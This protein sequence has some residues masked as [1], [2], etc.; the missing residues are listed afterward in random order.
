MM[1]SFSRSAS[2]PKGALTTVPSTLPDLIAAMR[3]GS[4]PICNIVASLTGSMPTRLSIALMPKSA[5]EP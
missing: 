3:A 5:E 2:V 4:S 1:L